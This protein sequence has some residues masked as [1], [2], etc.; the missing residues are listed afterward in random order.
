MITK[1]IREAKLSPVSWKRRGV[2]AMMMYPMNALVADQI[3]RLRRMIGSDSFYGMFTSVT[4][5]RRRPQFG[6]Y[7]GRTPY[8]GENNEKKNKELAATLDKGLVKIKPEQ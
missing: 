8:P 1:L 3:G 5:C 4:E 6:M 7:T 2:R